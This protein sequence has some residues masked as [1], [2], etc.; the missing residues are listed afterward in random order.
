MKKHRH[1][2]TWQGLQMAVLVLVCF[3]SA[4]TG[5]RADEPAVVRL[6]FV[7]GAVQVGQQDATQIDHAVAN[8]PLFNGSTIHTGV[9][10]QAEVEFAD[11]SVARLTPNS[12]LI[13]VHLQRLGTTGHTDLL[14]QNGLAYF[15]LNVG[16]GQR[17]TVRFATAVLHPMENSIFRVSL[18]KTPEAAVMQGSLHVDGTSAGSDFNS[19]VNTGESVHFDPEDAASS[20]VAQEITPESWDKWN[21]DRDAAI[22]QQAEN[23]TLVRDNSQAPNDPGW[24]DLD[25][26][27]NWYPVEGYGDVWT[28]SNVDAGWDPFGNGYWGNFQGYGATWVSG[29]PWGWLPYH[30]GAWN[31]FPFGWGW[32]PGGCGLGW[33]P[34][35]TVW[36]TPPGYRLPAWPKSGAIVPSQHRRPLGNGLIAVNRNV[37]VH[38][39]SAGGSTIL[40]NRGMGVR[41]TPQPLRVDGNTIQP[42]AA[43]PA[44][45]LLH[46]GSRPA[47]DPGVH[48]GVPLS[49]GFARP[50]TGSSAPGRPV[51]LPGNRI[52]AMPVSPREP[53]RPTYTAPPAMRSAPAPAPHMSAPPPA[54]AP[55][56]RPR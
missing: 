9:D 12:S 33:S 46:G 56:G 16:Q 39:K 35:V 43:I 40:G 44:S 30:C 7:Q 5:A 52:D 20:N 25:Y 48:V 15:E 2:A 19:E 26:Y 24:N 8:L 21:E 29:Y 45:G 47:Q 6:S 1:L 53:A 55:S 34:V 3:V 14:L 31:Y 37:G 38:G 54:A 28:P 41:A 22:A 10:G 49:G 36:N 32:V 42:I 23:Q 13:L 17:F 27:G 4:A 50:I 18:D 51:F 11:G